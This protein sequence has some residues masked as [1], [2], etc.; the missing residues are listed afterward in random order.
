[1]GI[2]GVVSRIEGQMI[3]AIFIR[4]YILYLILGFIAELKILVC[5]CL[6]LFRDIKPCGYLDS[7]RRKWVFDVYRNLL[8]S[9]NRLVTDQLMDCDESECLFDRALH[10]ASNCRAVPVESDLIT[11]RVV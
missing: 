1:M 4:S 11:V 2:I 6:T 5:D 9:S 7:S 3:G 10:L 8:P